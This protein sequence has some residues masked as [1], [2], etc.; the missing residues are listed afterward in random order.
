MQEKINYEFLVIHKSAV[1]LAGGRYCLRLFIQLFFYITLK[2][3][4]L[5]LIFFH[6]N[7]IYKHKKMYIMYFKLDN[8]KHLI[9]KYKFV[10]KNVRIKFMMEFL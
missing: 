5:R 9:L 1:G 8:L 6:L 4:N 3:C 10:L 7:Y 2:V